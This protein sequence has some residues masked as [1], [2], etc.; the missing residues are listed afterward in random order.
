ME[1]PDPLALPA[2]ARHGILAALA[3]MAIAGAPPEP[4]GTAD[5]RDRVYKRCKLA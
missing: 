3:A 2:P 4:S 1:G 5:H